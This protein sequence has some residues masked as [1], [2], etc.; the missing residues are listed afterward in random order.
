VSLDNRSWL[1]LAGGVLF[2]ALGWFGWS[3]LRPHAATTDAPTTVPV[4]KAD[5]NDK[6]VRAD[7]GFGLPD[8]DPSSTRALVDEREGYTVDVPDGWRVKD[9]T[10]GTHM[11]RAD[12]THGTTGVQIRV[13][14]AA[15]ASSVE[16][17]MP[18]HVE[19]F[20]HD[21]LS[22]WG[23]DIDVL[24]QECGTIGRHHGCKAALV[25]R[26]P[27]GKAWF[28]VQYVWVRGGRAYVM[29][30]GSPN[31]ERAMWEP[32]LDSVAASF[33]WRPR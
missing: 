10:S 15:G 25:H 23:G 16:A 28:L 32:V 4:A 29:Q 1:A 33:R 13:L 5:A 22:H 7:P 2:A 19:R 12:L 24:R 9:G 14:N 31:D 11:I 26:R 18:G 8:T 20:S 30:A 3:V 6:D 17:Y 21:M 27:D